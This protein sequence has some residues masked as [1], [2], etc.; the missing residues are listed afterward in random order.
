MSAL[1]SVANILSCKCHVRFGSLA[2]ITGRSR[3]VS[4]APESGHQPDIKQCPLCATSGHRPPI[5]LSNTWRGLAALA[6]VAD[7]VVDRDRELAHIAA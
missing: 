2:D 4:F 3:H 1:G 6:S 5:Q 7:G